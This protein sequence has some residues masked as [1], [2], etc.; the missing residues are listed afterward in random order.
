MFWVNNIG[1]ITKC[2]SKLLFYSS[3]GFIVIYKDKRVSAGY[4]L[5]IFP[6][7]DFT[8]DLLTI[9]FGWRFSQTWLFA[10][11]TERQFA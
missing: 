4:S 5:S 7:V 10:K 9:T 1:K 8:F 3:F 2:V 6:Y 11:I